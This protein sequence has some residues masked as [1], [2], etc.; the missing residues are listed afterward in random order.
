MLRSVKCK[1]LPFVLDPRGGK[2]GVSKQTNHVSIIIY[3]I[4]YT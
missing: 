3:V 2:G 4:Y 1:R